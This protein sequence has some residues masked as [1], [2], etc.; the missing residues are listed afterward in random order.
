[1]GRSCTQRPS[2]LRVLNSGRRTGRAELEH[3]FE[4]AREL[5]KGTRWIST[6]KDRSL[7]QARCSPIATQRWD[8]AE[9][10]ENRSYNR[11]REKVLR[12][13]KRIR[14]SRRVSLDLRWRQADSELSAHPG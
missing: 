12:R 5:S 10:I 2:A 7:W 8:C 13:R 6:G 9:P 4:E 1:M 14:N 3:N 11:K